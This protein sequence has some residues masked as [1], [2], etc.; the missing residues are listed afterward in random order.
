M[1][2]ARALVRALEI[3]RT[4][5]TCLPSVSKL[6]SFIGGR[7]RSAP[8]TQ[9]EAETPLEA[10]PQVDDDPAPTRRLFPREKERERERLQFDSVLQAYAHLGSRRG[11][12]RD[13]GCGRGRGRRAARLVVGAVRGGRLRPQRGGGGERPND[14]LG[15]ARAGRCD[16]PL[17]GTARKRRSGPA[18]ARAPR[19]SSVHFGNDFSKEEE[20]ALVRV[21]TFVCARGRLSLSLS[22]ERVAFVCVVRGGVTGHALLLRTKD[23][24]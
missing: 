13:R 2:P 11:R 3:V 19:P 1:S 21:S 16:R 20:H 9:S 7:P 15:D 14:A 4:S 5:D 23:T 10:R 18:R 24:Y 6:K 8:L 17:G 22:R 12:A